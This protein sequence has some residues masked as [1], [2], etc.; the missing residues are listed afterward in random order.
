MVF[1]REIGRGTIIC[2]EQFNDKNENDDD[3]M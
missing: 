3:Y 1:S 2:S